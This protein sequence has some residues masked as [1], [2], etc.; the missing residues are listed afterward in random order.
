MEKLSIEQR[1]QGFKRFFDM[2]NSEGPLLGFFRET[3][4]P[5]K[6]YRTETFLPGG[7]LTPALIEV[8]AFLPE[9]E[10]LF[11]LHEEAEGDFLWGAA[12]FWGIPWMEALVGCPVIADHT[13][14]SSRSEKP[15][16]LLGPDDI[17]AFDRDDPWAQKA[18]EFLQALVGQS[19][20]RFPL[21][22]TL[23][24]GISDLLAAVYGSP[25]FLFAL[26]DRPREMKRVVRKLTDLWIAFARSQL[27]VIPDFY[28]GTGSFYYE[29]WL[30][31][32]GVWLQEDASALMSPELFGE[33]I[34]PAVHE[35]AGSFDCSVIHLH[36]STY[37]P[38]EHLVE[39]PLSAVELHIDFGGPRA[40]ELYPY[41][42]RIL[43]HKPLIIW[44]DLT[45]EDLNFVARKLDRQAL[46]LL[47]VV[48]SREQAEEIWSRYK[49]G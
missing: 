33:Y 12:A 13:T 44:G 27:E 47:P 11:R 35:I 25:D 9:Y 10:R 48:A 43:D 45:P 3:Y 19:G 40:E 6:R 8:E 4:Y 29:A 15:K 30:P 42:R 34:A 39:A 26:M 46:A 36:P 31:G 21:A 17:P 18:V 16:Q 20:G 32:K 22:T 7:A 14:G 5:L 2:S 49:R 24:R 41:Y 1:V 28:G 37:I 38:V 23:M